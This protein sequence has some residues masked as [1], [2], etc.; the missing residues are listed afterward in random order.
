MLLLELEGVV[1]S[2][3]IHIGYQTGS[4]VFVGVSGGGV[5]AGYA[6]QFA[7]TA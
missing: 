6:I 7:M 1:F 4:M 3:A 5:Q 2:V